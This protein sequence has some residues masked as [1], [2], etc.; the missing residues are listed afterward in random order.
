MVMELAEGGSLA[1]LIAITKTSASGQGVQ[2]GEVLEMTWQLGS[3]LDYIHG[4]GILHRHIKADNILFARN[5]GAGPLCVK[6]ADFCVAAVLAT[7]VGS[8]FLSNVGHTSLL[9]PRARKRQGL[10]RQG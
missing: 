3:A 2:M 5:N 10:W 6:L 8:N 9:C 4:Q 1:D 7:G